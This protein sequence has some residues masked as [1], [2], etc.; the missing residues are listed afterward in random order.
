MKEFEKDQSHR[1]V[2]F[3]F[4]FELTLIETRLVVKKMEWCFKKIIF[5]VMFVLREEKVEIIKISKRRKEC[6]GEKTYHR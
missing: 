1:I 5:V 6:Q 4:E 2:F 3:G